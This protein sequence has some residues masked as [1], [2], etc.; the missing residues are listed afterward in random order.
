MYRFAALGT[1]ESATI[2]L[3]SLH[4]AE[5]QRTKE[6]CLRCMLVKSELKSSVLGSLLDLCFN[7]RGYRKKY[8]W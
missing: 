2:L 6:N 1:H 4:V 5:K 8:S 7:I 3:R